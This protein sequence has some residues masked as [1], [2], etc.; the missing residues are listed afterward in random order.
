MKRKTRL[1]IETERV[2]VI[3]RSTIG[4]RARCVACG[5]AASLVPVEE[6]AALARVSVRAIYRLVEADHLHFTE[7]AGEDLLV[8]LNSLCECLLRADTE[9][10]EQGKDHER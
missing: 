8:C 5:G 2:T 7:T 10:Y 3:R 6:A 4:C 9:P 1:T